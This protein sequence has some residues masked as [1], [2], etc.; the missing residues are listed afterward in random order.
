MPLKNKGTKV[1]Q[2][3]KNKF[4]SADFQYGTLGVANIPRKVKVHSKFGELN[5]VSFRVQGFKAFY[6]SFPKFKL[7]IL[8]KNHLISSL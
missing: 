6:N 5:F 4:C 8:F 7:N 2:N 3:T 1:K